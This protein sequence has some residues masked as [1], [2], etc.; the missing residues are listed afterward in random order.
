MIEHIHN[1]RRLLLC[2]V[3]AVV[4]FVVYLPVI[5]HQFVNYDDNV[6][7]TENPNVLSGLSWQSIKWAFTTGNA[8]NWH[9]LTWLSH[10]LD[11]QLFGLNAGAH[12]LVNVGFHVVNAVLVFVVFSRMTKRLW[13]SVFVA[14]LFALHPL[15]VESVAW[16]AER[17]DMLSTMFWFLTMLAYVRYVEGPSTGRYILALVLFALGLMSKP[18][19]V[20]LPIV[21]VLLDYWPLQRFLN[22]KFSILNSIIE[23][24][25]FFVLTAVSSIVTFVVQRK[26]GAIAVIVLKERVANAICSYLAYIGKMF[27]PAGLAVFYPHPAGFLPIARAVIYAAALVLITVFLI[28]QGRKYK[29]LIVGWFWYL[30]TLVPVIGIVQVGAQAMADRYTYVP[31]TGLFIIISFGAAEL[32]KG[33]PLRK[34]V[35]TASAA[36]ILFGCALVTSAQ[37]KYWENS[38]VLFDHALTVM[39]SGCITR[40]QDSSNLSGAKT[41]EHL[42]E[43]FKHIP[44]SP[45]IHNNFGNALEKMGKVDEA[46]AHY[47]FALELDPC[48]STSRYNLGR[49][50]AEQGKYEEAIEQYKIYL[51]SGVDVAQLREEMG[52]IL[53]RKG[54]TEDAIGQFQKALAEKPDSVAAMSFL[55]YALAQGGKTNE[56]VEYYRMALRIDPNDVITHGRLALALASVGKIDEAIEHCRIVLKALPNDVEM[57]TNLGILLQRQG[58]IDEAVECY[59]KAL[60]I[61]P[62]YKQARDCL[63]AIVRQKSRE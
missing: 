30:V 31:L 11:C 51:G 48:F 53:A 57:H 54:K 37:L 40:N 41:A 6:Y 27:W 7:V 1:H 63:D 15:H 38:I 24:V 3:L 39:E 42:A 4:T 59:R 29:Y 9:P 60:Q 50:L 62:T 34:F 26:G 23:K 35:L 61:D 17:K 28:Y 44:N 33:I 16:V 13:P 56:A 2:I 32:L 43:A 14:G 45:E 47:K 19:L 52:T 21:L 8:A 25:P 10:Q 18:M 46:I 22:S 5:N 20:T 36:V 58:K 55:G 12:H 49:A